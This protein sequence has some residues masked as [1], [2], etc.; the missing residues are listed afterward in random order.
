LKNYK[1]ERS[2]KREARSRQLTIG[3]KQ[4]EISKVLEKIKWKKQ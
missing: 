2:K 1:M 4:K 3:S